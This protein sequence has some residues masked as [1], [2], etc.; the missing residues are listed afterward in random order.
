MKSQITLTALVL[1]VRL[2]SARATV[3]AL[4]WTAS[5]DTNVVSYNIYYGT[6]SGNY[7]TKVAV[8]TVTN[9]VISNLTAGVTYYFAATTLDASGRE[10]SFSN[11]TSYLA[12]GLLVFSRGTVAGGAATINFP[13]EPAHWY[14]VQ[15]TTNFQNW[16]TIGQTG[17][18]TSNA[19]TQFTDLA[20]SA[21]PSRFYR[22][23]L[24]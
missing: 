3:T 8:G 24:H 16:T 1:F 4:G 23:V 18:A 20:A 21:Y 7:T 5:T 14:E 12:P 11:E 6:A 19:W 15:A 13:V 17:A 9:V 2:F 10:S 22:L